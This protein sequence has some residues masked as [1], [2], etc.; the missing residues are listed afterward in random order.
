MVNATVK[1]MDTVKLMAAVLLAIASVAG[2]YVYAEH[3]MAYRV[4]GLILGI[5]AAMIIAFQT[6][7]GRTIWGFLQGAQ[8]EVRK[9]V[10]PTKQETT[11]TTLIVV[12]VVIVVAV[13]LWLLDMFL[14]WTVG[15]LM[16]RRG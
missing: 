10:W 13:I 12:L 6:A 11:Q 16:G 2:F 9:V 14:G 3:I 7:I 5:V 15:S 4:G 1:G 8:I